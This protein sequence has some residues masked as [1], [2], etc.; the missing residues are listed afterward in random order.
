MTPL[1]LLS[2]VAQA[3]IAYGTPLGDGGTTEVKVGELRVPYGR[4]QLADVSELAFAGRSIGQ[5]GFMVGPDIGLAVVSRPG[6]VTLIGGVFTGGGRDAAARGLPDELGNPL[7]VTRL[8]VGDVHQDPFALDPSPDD[9]RALAALYV[10]GLYMRDSLV[11]GST[12]LAVNR[13]DKSVL[14]DEHWNPYIAASA[15]DWWQAG[16]DA[17]VRVPA[18]AWAVAAELQGDLAGYR[19]DQGSVLAFGARVQAAVRRGPI[20]VAARWAVLVPDQAFP[21]GGTAPIREITPAVGVYFP[22]RHA[23]VVFDVPILLAAPVFIENGVGGHV[24]TERPGE[25]SLIAEGGTVERRTVIRAR[26]ALQGAL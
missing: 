22:G 15:G 2:T 1:L 10:N 3:G 5:L 23:R 18:G 17:A 26:L 24:G 20:E 8:G 4:E 16:V 7:L 11:G 12:R 25:A 19:N 6:P 21:T 13:A 14:L 9:D